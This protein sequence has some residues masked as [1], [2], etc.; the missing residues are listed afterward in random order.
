MNEPNTLAAAGYLAGVWAPGQTSPTAMMDALEGQLRMH[1]AAA[2]A[3]H[4]HDPDAKVGIAYIDDTTYPYQWWD[5]TDQVATRTYDYVGNKWF[6]DSLAAGKALRPVGDGE[7][8]PGLKGS[9]DF[10]G[11][12]FYGREWGDFS[13]T[14]GGREGSPIVGHSNPE[15]EG[16]EQPFDE[17]G[18]YERILAAT[19]K[20][21]LPVLITESGVDLPEPD[22]K[23]RRGRAI[24]DTLA[25][26]KHANDDG[27]NV[28]GYL[29]WT[30][31]DSPEWHDGWSQHYGLFGFDP[32]T[33]RRWDKPA[34]ATFETIARR[35][36]IPA[37][38]LSD[39]NRESP[40]RRDPHAAH[41]LHVL[42]P[43]WRER[44]PRLRYGVI[45]ATGC[46]LGT[47]IFGLAVSQFYGAK[48][49]LISAVALA[50]VYVF[51]AVV[52]RMLLRSFDMDVDAARRPPDEG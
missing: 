17:E 19:N 11:L 22:T 35:K 30:D 39:D 49:G 50:P 4:K 9:L 23:N 44:R 43:G 52:L 20:F 24:V 28:F 12:N 40:A 25:A 48:A 38:W 34:A 1:A 18:M 45:T 31:W 2:T 37:E 13:I 3:V 16:P 29:H 10:V 51:I 46:L 14:G 41:E 47:G 26:I 6:L 42:R 7:E 36:A 8:I 33:G 27:A 15:S 21:H 5:P 32:K